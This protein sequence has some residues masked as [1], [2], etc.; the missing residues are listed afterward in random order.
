MN[1]EMDVT[2]I[3]E[4]CGSADFKREVNHGSMESANVGRLFPML[5][6]KGDQEE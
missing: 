4:V 2:S 3:F 5:K 1:R 6:L